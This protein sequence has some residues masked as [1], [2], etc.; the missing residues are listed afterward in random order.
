MPNYFQLNGAYN[1]ISLFNSQWQYEKMKYP[2]IL[3][4]ID[5]KGNTSSWISKKDYSDNCYP[6]LKDY[7]NYE[8]NKSQDRK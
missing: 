2:R 8:R 6:K 3:S 7:P 1:E 5:G 4:Y